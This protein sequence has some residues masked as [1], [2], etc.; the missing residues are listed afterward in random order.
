MRALNLAL[1]ALL[2]GASA[3]AQAPGPPGSGVTAVGTGASS[4]ALPM[5]QSPALEA[6]HVFKTQPG[7]LYSL[8][9][10]NT[11][12]A[13][14]VLLIDGTTVP[15]DGALTSCGTTNP[16]GCLKACYPIGLG[17]ATAPVYGGLQMQPGPPISFA[18]GIVAVYSSTGCTTKTLGAANIFFE[19]QVY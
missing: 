5:L 18:N 14:F 16:A 1:L 9:I 4:Q 19:A 2:F 3:F 11:G 7:N 12:A 10:V 15:A 6:S 8:G 17:T 13:G